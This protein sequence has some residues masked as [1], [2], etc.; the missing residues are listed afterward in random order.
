MHY[1]CLFAALFLILSLFRSTNFPHN[2]GHTPLTHVIQALGDIEGIYAHLDA[3]AALGVRG[4]RTLGQRLEEHRDLVELYQRLAAICCKVP[5]GVDLSHLE[6][7]V[8]DVAACHRFPFLGD[9]A[10]THRRMLGT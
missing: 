5:L 1:L 3:V 10:A 7:Q 9:W 4:S 6:L 2:L 8:P